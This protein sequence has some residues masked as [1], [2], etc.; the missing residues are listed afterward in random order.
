MV[1][2][3]GPVL[4]TELQGELSW[5]DDLAFTEFPYPI[6]VSYKRA[7]DE[8]DWEKKTYACIQVFEVALRFFA[9]A[10]ASQ[11]VRD[12][13]LFNDNDPGLNS[14]L[15]SGLRRSTLGL[16]RAIFIRILEAY[17]GKRSVFF[18]PELYDRYWD[19]STSP[20][21][22][23]EDFA[24]PFERL[25]QIRNDLSHGGR[26]TD[27]VAWR[28]LCEEA[29]GLLHGILERFDFMENYDL[30]RI[31]S[32]RGEEYRYEIY[33]GLQVK[34][35]SRP[36]RTSEPLIEGW[37]YLSKGETR[38]LELHPLLILWESELAQSAT[39]RMRDAAIFDRFRMTSLVYLLTVLGGRAE[40]SDPT[41]IAE[42]SRMVY[43]GIERAKRARREVRKLTWGL[44]KEIANQVSLD[45]IGDMPSRYNRK[46]YLQREKTRESFRKF[47]A[48][49]KTCLVLIGKS[50][51]GKSEFLLSLMDEYHDSSGVCPLMYHGARFSTDMEM[52]EVVTRDFELYLA[53]KDWAKTEGVKD[54]L[55]EINRIEG[56]SEKKMVILIDGLNEN[57]DARLLL[58]RVDALVESSP[59]P[60]L[61]VVINSRP[62]TWRT[63]KRGVSLAKHKYFRAEA[64]GELG[65][66][67]HLLGIEL[68]M[69]PFSREEL[70]TAYARYQVEYELT[71]NYEDIQGEVREMLRDPWTLW[72]VAETYGG[73]EIPRE[74]STSDLVEDYI[75]ALV[76]S[77]KLYREDIRF[78]DIE[79]MRLMIQEGK[80]GNVLSGEE[81]SLA[82]TGDGRSLFE[83]IHS[84]DQLSTGRRV[85]QSY[86]NLADADIL[87]ER[88][89]ADDYQIAFKHERFYEYFGS[90][91][92][93]ELRDRFP[94]AQHAEWYL[95]I[96]ESLP[97]YPFLWGPLR[98]IVL[99]ECELGH[100]EPAAVLAG[101][102]TQLSRSLAVSALEGHGHHSVDDVRLFVQGILRRKVKG[103]S[104]AKVVAVRVA[105][106]L[107]IDD[108]L[109]TA[110]GSRERTIRSAAVRETHGIWNAHPARGLSFLRRLQD[111]MPAFFNPTRYFALQ[112]LFD[113]SML[114]L[115]QHFRDQG[116]TESLRRIWQQV[117]R[118]VLL[119]DDQ[120]PRSLRNRIVELFLRV[121]IRAVHSLGA[122]TEGDWGVPANVDEFAEHFRQGRG[123]RQCL[124][125]LI[126]YVDAGHRSLMDAQEHLMAAAEGRDV[127]ITYIALLVLHGRLSQGDPTVFDAIKSM[128]YLALQACPPTPLAGLGIVFMAGMCQ[129]E[130]HDYDTDVVLR[131][132][133]SALNTYLRSAAGQYKTSLRTYSWIP[134]GHYLAA[135]FY[136]HRSLDHDIVRFITEIMRGT[137]SPGLLRS[138]AEQVVVPCY[139]YGL[140]EAS[141]AW[142]SVLAPDQ[143]ENVKE[144]VQAS[145]SALHAYVPEDVEDIMEELDMPQALRQQTRAQA[146]AKMRVLVYRGG[147]LA[148]DRIALNP[149]GSLPVHFGWWLEQARGCRNLDG[150]LTLMAKA[151]INLVFER[152]VFQTSQPLLPE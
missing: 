84:D 54:I 56:I 86:A 151:L 50:G 107:H 46:I 42:F 106:H 70:R 48:S 8:Q 66:E 134:I 60:W 145:L 105:A 113:V 10:L 83:L 9:L 43:D 71:T 49:D 97:D 55:L 148:I 91:R 85:N 132:A 126:P 127:L 109:L 141:M 16:W 45:R 12:M 26:P 98:N 89:T 123:V 131:E 116:L 92:L 53:L 117:L 114:I 88:G 142:L 93:A 103:D 2:A 33:A 124:S 28:A 135:F 136:K 144:I 99:A 23:R 149:D 35:A 94:R 133:R 120:N 39:A 21:R 58:R 73:Q 17:Q 13:D 112:S 11:Y 34:S 82:K 6:A 121:A 128:T 138:L 115:F 111:E 119:I 5:L 37:F 139:E 15:S 14:L 59:Y 52:R 61:K 80:Y 125:R 67:T 130:D 63:I 146:T 78:L 75:A 25:T 65:G 57:P 102:D 76:R 150:W 1:S 118:R 87:I 4:S 20:H 36:I 44:L 95:N 110:L 152:K 137:A 62:E 104:L 64:T 77:G 79:L 19:A 31:L 3:S 68:E 81:I 101:T 47:L 90:K 51:V 18:I 29:F 24:T 129:R 32:A 108:V 69:G 30:I 27:V 140:P 74:I 100:F 22:A 72:L 96:A 7:L 41:L 143:H 38:F 40:L 122:H 147:S